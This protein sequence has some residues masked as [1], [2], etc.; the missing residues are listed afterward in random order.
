MRCLICKKNFK[1]ITPM[2]LKNKHNITT[3]QYKELFPT[4]NIKM[5]SCKKALKRTQKAWET[6]RK[7]GTDKKILKGVYKQCLFCGIDF[8]ASKSSVRK[9]HTKECYSK[10]QKGKSL[11]L[12]TCKN[13]SAAQMGHPTS[14]ETRDKISIANSGENN[15]MY[16]N[17]Y[18]DDEIL[19]ISAKSKEVSKR[20]EVIEKKRKYYHSE[21]GKRNCRKGGLIKALKSPNKKFYDTK[22]ELKVK[23]IL[24]KNEIGFIHPF[25][26]WNIKHC[27]AA[28][29]YL[30][31]FNLILEADGKYWH[32]YPFGTEQDSIRNAEIKEAG[33]NLLRVW[34]GEIEQTKL[35]EEI[36]KYG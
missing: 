20:P 1:A 15:G 36:K 4:K 18:T 2:H 26:I 5:I 29:F 27:Y 33:Y 21:E 28:D 30:P 23:G 25:P 9:F 35:L 31:E 17:V 8:Y 34:E 19:R 10:Y 13:M 7:R 22:P 32:N 12:E 3:I 16:G 24:S 11:P 6:K 14:K